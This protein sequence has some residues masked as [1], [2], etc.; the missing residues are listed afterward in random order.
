MITINITIIYIYILTKITFLHPKLQ[1]R[2]PMPRHKKIPCNGG[3]LL[4]HADS[5][6]PDLAES[7]CCT[8]EAHDDA[9][10]KAN[11]T[12]D[13]QGIDLT[14]QVSICD[15]DRGVNFETLLLF[16]SGPTPVKAY[17]LPRRGLS[18]P[19]Q[20]MQPEGLLPRAL[21]QTAGTTI[22]Q[23]TKKRL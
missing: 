4:H 5:Q 13:R 14:K 23:T 18:W 19:P 2:L 1:L 10:G 3:V 17:F 9:Q 16:D 7:Q 20:R 15:C 6:R 22:N 12:K 21:R 8:S 11:T